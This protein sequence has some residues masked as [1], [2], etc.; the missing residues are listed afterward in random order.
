MKAP[1]QPVKSAKKYGSPPTLTLSSAVPVQQLEIIVFQ[2]LQLA[3][4]GFRDD[5][6]HVTVKR[7]IA[8]IEQ[9]EPGVFHIATDHI[10]KRPDPA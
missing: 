3:H 6:N 7:M 5:G 2:F 10:V 4:F 9:H 8:K 1:N